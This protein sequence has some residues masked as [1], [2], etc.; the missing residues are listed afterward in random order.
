MSFDNE[1][2]IRGYHADFYGHVNNARY[3][4]FFEEARWTGLESKVDL[5]A[6]SKKGLGFLVVNIN[7]N[8][9]KAVPV[10]ETLLISTEL[11]EVGNRSA[12][13]R[14]E[15]VFKESRKVAAD[16]LVTFVII[17]K[18]GRAVEITGDIKKDL[19]KLEVSAQ[20]A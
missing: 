8:Y 5:I 3:L 13:L 12:V 7:I 10:G 19:E 17:D 9:R 6:W 4:E 14:Q 20:P 16:C 18:T 1:I 15:A 2:K 11:V